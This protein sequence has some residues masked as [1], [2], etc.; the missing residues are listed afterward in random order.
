MTTF[1]QLGLVPALL[2]AIAERGFVTPT[3]IQAEMIPF[4][5]AEDRDV[6]GLAQT[7]TGKTAA[8]GLPILQ[9][10][11][12]R[13]R[14]TQAL[15]LTPTRELGI[16]VARE[17]A[18]LLEGSMGRTGNQT[19]GPAAKRASVGGLNSRIRRGQTRCETIRI[20]LAPAGVFPVLRSYTAMI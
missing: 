11:D 13:S 10:L 9:K 12:L 19:I 6:T 1:D 5:L 8:F 18:A 17:S 2:D 20:A 14:S 3:P 15:I 7:G 4:L 16:Q